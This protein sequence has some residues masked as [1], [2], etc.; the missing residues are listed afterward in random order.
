MTSTRSELASAI[1]AHVKDLE[2][3]VRNA[4]AIPAPE[5]YELLG[6]LK[7]ALGH[8]AGDLLNHTGDKLLASLK[9][10]DVTDSRGDAYDNAE[11]AIEHLRVAAR[12]AGELGRH[13][14]HAQTAIAGQGYNTP[15]K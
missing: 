2:Q 11:V 7:W 10:Y 15:G 14:E 3:R 9:V 5:A 6:E 4:D 1:D 8:T 12:L 13:L